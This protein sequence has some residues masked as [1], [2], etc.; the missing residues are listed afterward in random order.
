MVERVAQTGV[1][2]APDGTVYIA[3]TL[4]SRLRRVDTGGNI[5]TIAGT[6][7]YGYNGD[8]KDGNGTQLF[9]PSEVKVG[10]DGAVYLADTVHVVSKRPGR[11]VK[12][13][14]VDLP[15]PRDLESSFEPEF[16]AIVHELRDAISQ[17]RAA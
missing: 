8:G 14:A 3:D 15:R 16:V 6:G 9:Q 5:F 13:K 7:A 1:A 2:V 10:S 11:I 17:V 12:T 4:N